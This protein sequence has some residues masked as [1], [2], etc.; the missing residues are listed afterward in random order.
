M[1]LYLKYESSNIYGSKDT[2]VQDKVF[3]NKVKVQYQGHKVKSFGTKRK[4]Y[5]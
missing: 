1:H 5:S 2:V 4:V 3:Q